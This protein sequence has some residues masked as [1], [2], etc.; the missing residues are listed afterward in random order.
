MAL[1]EIKNL[2][3]SL[4]SGNEIIQAVDDISF[5]LEKGKTFCLV[6]ESGSGKSITALALIQ[7]LPLPVLH[8]ISGQLP[9]E[10]PLEPLLEPPLEPPKTA[11]P[12]NEPPKFVDLLQLEETQLCQIR[13]ARI[14]MI[15]QEPMTSLNP[16]FTIGT[17]IVEALQLHHSKP[18]R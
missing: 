3:V 9:F 13:G 7:L 6:G 8:H 17:Q 10:L 15:F 2:C 18:I 11:E 4:R 14:A 5:S 16:V 1:L 12:S